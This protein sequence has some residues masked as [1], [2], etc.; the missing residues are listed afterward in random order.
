MLDAGKLRHR[1]DIEQ[2]TYTQN[3]QTGEMTLTWTTFAQS[4]PASI[5]PLS[6]REFIQAAAVQSDVTTRIVI[7][8][9]TGVTAAMRIKHGATL[10]NIR[11]VLP[12]KVTGREYITL[13][14]SEGVSDG[15]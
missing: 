8:Y 1:V 14:C 11:G 9:R 12:D 10:Y 6:A 2:Q 15:Q 4:I 7:R 13:P 5:E 3:S